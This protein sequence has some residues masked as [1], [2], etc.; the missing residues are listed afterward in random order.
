MELKVIIDD[1]LYALNVPDEI[2]HNADDLFSRMDRDM[3][4]GWQMGRDW[5]PHPGRV[6][7]LQIVGN[8]LLTALENEDHNLGRMM[9]AYILSR[10]PEI[11]SLVLDTSGEMQNT[12]VR[13]KG[14]ASAGLSFSSSADASPYMPDAEA[15][16]EAERQVSGVY[17]VGRH[18]SFSVLNPE[19]GSW[20]TVTTGK[21]EA[22]AEARRR[23]MLLQRY[24]ALA[25]RH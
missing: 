23:E 4:Q 7:R 19:D 21:D 18:F 8:K 16:A 6:E 24:N 25:V 14:A 12:E 3:D 22:E 17:K 9:A 5:V 2:V 20:E 15:R 11:D 1:E 13:F 10:A